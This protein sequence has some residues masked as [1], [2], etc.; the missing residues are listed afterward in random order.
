MNRFAL[1][2]EHHALC[3][4]L[5]KQNEIITVKQKEVEDLAKQVEGEEQQAIERSL[6][7]LRF[8]DAGD[9]KEEEVRFFL[10]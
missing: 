2:Q 4:K 1:E 10:Y 7:L 9:N 6:N 8:D 3:E 5:R